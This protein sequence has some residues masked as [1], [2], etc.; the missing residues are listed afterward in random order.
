MMLFVFLF[1]AWCKVTKRAQM[2]WWIASSPII[3]YCIGVI[4][5]GSLGVLTAI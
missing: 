3:F 5:F 2:S 1:L 4:I